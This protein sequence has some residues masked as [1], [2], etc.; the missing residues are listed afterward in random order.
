MIIRYIYSVSVLIVISVQTLAAQQQQEF[1]D[2]VA[3]SSLY[4]TQLHPSEPDPPPVFEFSVKRD[5]SLLVGGAG[6]AV[7]GQLIK[8]NIAPLTEAQILAL[9]PRDINS[10]DRAAT[11]QYRTSD[12][13]L[14]NYLLAASVV[15]PLSVLASRSVRREVMPI[16]VMYLETGALAGGITNL[17]KGIFKRKRPYVYNPNVPMDEKMDINA[18]Q[19]F[20]SG[21]VANSA[22]FLFLTASMVNRYAD[23]PAWKWVAWSSAVVVP[24]TIAYWRYS[25]GK[26]FPTDVLVGYL[27]G[28]GSGL[29]IPALHKGELPKDIS[30]NLQPLSNG[31]MLTI[32]F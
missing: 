7:V 5:L 1:T 24:G 11:R 31:V 20:F 2:S 27:I 14:S 21:H 25:S 13:N 3:G 18:R 22:A 4:Q 29:L 26:H 16:L 10:F 30:Y 9:D 12:A 32:T 17:S 8:S 6:L 15:S 23:R 19:S 28:A